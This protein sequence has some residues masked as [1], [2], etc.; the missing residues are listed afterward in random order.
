[1]FHKRNQA[2]Q[3]HHPGE[4]YRNHKANNGNSK[5]W[6]RLQKWFRARK[7]KRKLQARS[8]KGLPFKRT[9]RPVAS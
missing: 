6:K 9:M 7:R 8:R 1:M 4:L 5:T 3:L 2:G